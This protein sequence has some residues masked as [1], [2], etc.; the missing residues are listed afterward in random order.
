MGN[1]H[2]TSPI[3]VSMIENVV[4]N[5]TNMGETGSNLANWGQMEPNQAK[6]G[7]TRPSQHGTKDTGCF[8]M[9]AKHSVIIRC[10]KLVPVGKIQSTFYFMNG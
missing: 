8:R 6:P 2:L 9:T 10:Q 4:P 7:Q 5:R 3:N 1:N